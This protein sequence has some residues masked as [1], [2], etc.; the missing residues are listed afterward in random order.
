MN[1]VELCTECIFSFPAF[2]GTSLIAVAP[3]GKL[4]RL[5]HKKAFLSGK[6]NS[7]RAPRLGGEILHPK[8][9]TSQ[10]AHTANN[11]PEKNGSWH[12]FF[13]CVGDGW[14]GMGHRGTPFVHTRGVKHG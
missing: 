1:N 14:H 11:T 4:A 8:P 7:L 3:T 10:N 5:F 13:F 6:E 12:L 2:A 9:Y